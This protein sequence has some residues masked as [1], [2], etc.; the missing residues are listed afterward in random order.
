MHRYK[1]GD[2]VVDAV[3]F[4]MT[5]VKIEPEY[6]KKLGW[7]TKTTDKSTAKE[8]PGKMLEYGSLLINSLGPQ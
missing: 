3:P 5:G 8:L 4:Q 7:N 1:I 2:V 6:V